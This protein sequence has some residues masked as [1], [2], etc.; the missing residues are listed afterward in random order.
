MIGLPQVLFALSCG[1]L[2]YVVAGY[3]LLLKISARFFPKPIR[4]GEFLPSV[5][6]VIPVRNGEAYLHDKLDS[7]LVLDYP[8]EL[9]EVLV[10][11]HG[12]TDETDSIARGYAAWDVRLLE[13]ESGSKAAALNAGIAATRSSIVVLSEAWQIMERGC[14]R[15]MMKC[16]AD[17]AV[18]VVS[19]EV[20]MHGRGDSA[21][22]RNLSLF[23]NLEGWF[24]A[25]LSDLD[26]MLGAGGPF[27]AIRRPLMPRIP[28]DILLDDLYVA[29]AAFL[30]GY[31]VV[32]EP[33]AAV[34]DDSPPREPG[35]GETLEAQAGDYQLMKQYG[36]LS[37]L[38][39][40]RFHYFS[41]KLAR[42]LLPFALIIIAVT[43]FQLHSRRVMI[44]AWAVQGLLYGLAIAD[45]WIGG[46]SFL[47]RSSKAART[48]VVTMFASLCAL[49]V[50]FV[51]VRKLWPTK[52]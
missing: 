43:S 48:F 41:Y 39:R 40:M 7:V 4:K 51:P 21:G 19:G 25:R 15:E 10:I 35:F 49:A 6:I 20:I 31:R 22:E 50:L 1:L 30:R 12:S 8:R 38:N 26:S 34:F 44:G 3:P 17:A 16:F 46:V 28:S 9:L 5:A 29:M 14:V 45:Q 33:M 52:G 32:V 18:G 24:G 27:Y 23:A 11:S 2:F 42:L 37:S 36:L 47:K 13:L